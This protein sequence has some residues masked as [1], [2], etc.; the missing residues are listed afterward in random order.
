MGRNPKG[1]YYRP[2]RWGSLEL[3]VLRLFDRG[4]TTREAAQLLK[5]SPVTVRDAKRRAMNKLG[6]NNKA[7]LMKLAKRKGLV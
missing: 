7:E 6:A 4:L 1:V 3:H 2:M 5:R